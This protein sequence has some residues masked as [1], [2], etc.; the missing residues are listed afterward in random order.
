[1]IQ[2]KYHI[3]GRTVNFQISRPGISATLPPGVPRLKQQIKS[4]PIGITIEAFGVQ[5]ACSFIAKAERKFWHIQL[6]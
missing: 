5:K 3:T 2:K 1:M 6:E 4:F